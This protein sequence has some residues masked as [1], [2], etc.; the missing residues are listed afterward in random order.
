[1]GPS[2]YQVGD[3]NESASNKAPV[4][5]NKSALTFLLA[6]VM[7]NIL[8]STA[9]TI[10][11]IFQTAVFLL[12]LPIAIVDMSTRHI[13]H[14]ERAWIL[15]AIAIAAYSISL[16]MASQRILLLIW[17]IFRSLAG[18][19]KYH[20]KYIM[21]ILDLDHANPFAI[22]CYRKRGGLS[23]PHPETL[24]FH[25]FLHYQGCKG[26]QDGAYD[27]DERVSRYSGDQPL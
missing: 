22:G 1:M 14:K 23:D 9:K 10:K 11:G 18:I 17:Q 13:K 16:L 6:G 26:H 15:F 12:L 19:Y 24:S 4:A 20:Q 3:V 8:L 5:A 2:I 25:G 7:F 21:A 27:Q